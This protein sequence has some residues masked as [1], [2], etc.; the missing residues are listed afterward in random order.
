MIS[1][2][3]TFQDVKGTSIYVYRWLPA[4]GVPV[5]AV[6]QIAHGMAEKAARYEG[7]AITL[8]TNGYAVYANDHKGH[9]KTAPSLEDVGYIG[10]SGFHGMLQDMAQ[11]TQ[12]IKSTYADIPV[13]LL[14][15]SMGSFLTQGYMQE[16]GAELQGVILS[17]T[18][19]DPGVAIKPGIFL[20]KIIAKLYGE[21]H[22]SK[23]L[24]YLV[25]GNYNNSFKPLRTPFDWLS[26][27]EIEV[28][29]YIVDPYCGTLF[30][31][32]FFRDFFLF[33]Q[34]LYQVQNLSR[35]P[36]QL[37]VYLFSGSL[38]PVGLKSKGVMNLIGAYEKLHLQDITYRFYEGGRH[39]MFNEIN[40]DEVI[41]DL[42]TWLEEKTKL[43][44]TYR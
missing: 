26:R 6:V 20:A 24:N 9:G 40:R 33:L 19:G 27:D 13:F 21:R 14:G 44:A 3:F 22:K 15:H 36:K 17:G 2:P 23:A 8:T 30:T 28:N 34:E 42:L 41:K 31:T 10:Q 25:F 32:S 1:L 43:K 29:K 7:L 12:I 5:K 39:E 18:N 35:I 37:P 4:E 11:L 38:D 16:Y